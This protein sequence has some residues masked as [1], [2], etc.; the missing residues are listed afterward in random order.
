MYFKYCSDDPNV[1]KGIFRDHKIR[2]T[3][4]W[5]MNDPLEFNPALQFVDSKVAHQGYDLNG[6]FL[7][8]ID[9]FYRI[10]VIESLINAYGILSL[11]T[12]PL[13]FDM[14]SRY[15]NGHKGFVLVFMPD[16]YLHQCMK[17]K[18][19]KQNI[20]REVQYVENQA[21]N[22]E[23][24][25]SKFKATIPLEVIQN[26]IFFKKTA[27]WQDEQEYRLVRPLT[28]YP[29]YKPKAD[30][31]HRDDFKY[32]FDFSLECIHGV[33]FGPSMSVESKK[34]I[35]GYC[36]NKGSHIQF[37]Q[38]YII[39]DEADH[40]G[41][42]SK[43]KFFSIVD[44]MGSLDE[45][46]RIKP[47]QYCVDNLKDLTNAKTMKISQLSDLPYYEDYKELVNQLFGKLKK[48]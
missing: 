42:P 20:F 21:L 3:Q 14:W 31:S 33:I 41:K 25:A 24:L 47:Q 1:I 10:Q 38:A 23:E 11:T 32:L 36:S 48:E 18:D 45:I 4:P 34:S 27:R 16:F 44:L 43:M 29:K 13:S 30:H 22:I 15:A 40:M 39:R 19:D 9:L 12:Q 37:A 46:Y 35:I 8:S 7:P 5:G 17:S 6:F 28:D 26:E 2:F